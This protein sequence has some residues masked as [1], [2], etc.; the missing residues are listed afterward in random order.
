MKK[1]IFSIIGLIL[2]FQE[3]IA[4]EITTNKECHKESEHISHNPIGVMGDHIH[5][6]GSIMFSY[7]FMY[8]N[9]TG[10]LSGGN[11]IEDTDIFLNYMVSP[12]SMFM[13]MH[14]LGTMYSPTDKLTLMLMTNYISNTMTLKTKMGEDFQTQ[15]AGIGDLNIS[16][17]IQI[18][19]K[20]QTNIHLNIGVGIP[21]GNID[22]RDDT[23]MMINSQLAY[24]MQL[25][26]KT[27][28]PSIGAT[29]LGQSKNIFWGAQSLYKYRIGENL[30]NYT[31]GDDFITTAWGS[32]KAFNKLNLSLRAKY[33]NSNKIKGDGDSDLNP[34]MMPLFN[35]NNSGK[36]KLD[37]LG[38]VNLHLNEGVFKG[39]KIGLEVGY[40]I[41]QEVL[42]T[43]MNNDFSAIFGLQFTING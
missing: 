21:T 29:Y 12:Q 43:Q 42:G 25:G 41:Y 16:G 35:T 39:L 14:M 6:K 2:L 13:G 3:F 4:Q 8:M 19:N 11:T 20:D 37:L 17:L 1:T 36:S 10:N 5:H 30:E 33:M 22:Q 18:L 26:S 27:W 31:L 23:P 38:G 9:M 32:I 28:D 34:M 24:P 40:P 7:R 15:S